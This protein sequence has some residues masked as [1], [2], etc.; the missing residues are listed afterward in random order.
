MA[1]SRAPLTPNDVLR[2]DRIHLRPPRRDE[3]P[4]VRWL[5]SDPH[6]MAPVGGAIQLTDEKASQWY[7]RMVDP[8]RPTDCYCLIFSEGNRPVGEISFH[9]WD[10]ERLTA[11]LNL[12]IA[13]TD[14][15][16]GYARAA[17]LLFL[18]YFFNQFGGQ[19]L[20]D[21]VALDNE[22]GQQALLEFGF[23]HDPTV[24][25]VFMLRMTR[26]RFNTLGQTCRAYDFVG[27]GGAI[28]PKDRR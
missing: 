21:D 15:R 4:Y 9:R 5:W 22:A 28:S 3:M 16:K 27:E 23:E 19:V 10:A 14:R 18:D 12:K 13:S 24:E 2:A 1:A 25:D 11:G 20:T 8:G 7:A 6:T 26:Q 17:M